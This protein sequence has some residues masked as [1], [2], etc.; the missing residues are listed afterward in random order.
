MSNKLREYRLV[1][2]SRKVEECYVMAESWEDAESQGLMEQDWEHMNSQD[3]IEVDLEESA[4][5]YD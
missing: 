3:E 1:R 5:E 2:V 4:D